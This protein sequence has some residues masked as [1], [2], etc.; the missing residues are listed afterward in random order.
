MTMKL[1]RAATPQPQTWRCPPC[2]VRLN[3]FPGPGLNPRWWPRCEECGRP[4]VRC[5]I[6]GRVLVTRK[7]RSK[8]VAEIPGQLSL[9]D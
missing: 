4:M 8:R 3:V 7:P 5:N 9:L 6:L 2:D 1:N